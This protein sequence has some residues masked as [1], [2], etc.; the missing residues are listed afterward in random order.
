[1][2]PTVVPVDDVR[3]A[4]GQAAE[5]VPL[6]GVVDDGL[7]VVSLA[8]FADVESPLF[9]ASFGAE[10]PFEDVEAARESVR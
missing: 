5:P 9:A 1:M 4:C 2:A 7:L 8:G 6:A 10:L 3:R